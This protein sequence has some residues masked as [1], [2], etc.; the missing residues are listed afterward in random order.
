MGCDLGSSRSLQ[1]RLLFYSWLSGAAFASEEWG[2][3]NYFFDWKDYAL[4]EYGRISLDFQ[5]LVSRYPRPC[6][7]VPLAL[8]LPPD[9][10]GI[11]N[12]YLTEA[13]EDFPLFKC[14]AADTFHRNLR[15]FAHR[16]LAARPH[17]RGLDDS[18]LTPSPYIGSFDV[19]GHDAPPSLLDQYQL[20][21]Y[22]D[23]RQ[24]DESTLPSTKTLNYQATEEQ[25]AFCR[26]AIH[27]AWPF[28]IEGEVGCAVA[29]LGER[30]IIG[31]FNNLGVVKEETRESYLP[32]ATRPVR[33]RGRYN[34]VEVL[35]GSEFI[36]SAGRESLHLTIPA[37]EIFLMSFR[38]NE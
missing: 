36:H 20:V 8:V 6:P 35:Y 13:S 1:R 30:S 26:D 34:D 10:P 32:E 33:L 18:N 19:L 17:A 28:Q 16:L 29:T 21:V 3:E 15:H 9:V 5:K 22:F 12:L 14:L 37:G 23:Q 7:V 25:V 31:I 2:P 38:C 27:A 4:S 24:R 11:D